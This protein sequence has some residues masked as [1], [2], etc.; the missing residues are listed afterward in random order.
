MNNY[1]IILFCNFYLI[2]LQELR[3]TTNQERNKK[4]K[5]LKIIDFIFWYEG[6]DELIT[7]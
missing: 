2:T 3:K 6:C 1:K 5:Q 7:N 4:N